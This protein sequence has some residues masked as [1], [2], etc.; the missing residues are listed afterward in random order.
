MITKKNRKNKKTQGRKI[1][2]DAIMIVTR[3]STS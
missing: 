2:P 1:K 3:D